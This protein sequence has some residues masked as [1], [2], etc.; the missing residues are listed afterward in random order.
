M[1]SLVVSPCHN[2]FLLCPPRLVS[3]S[4]S[5]TLRE[6]AVFC[7]RSGKWVMKNIYQPHTTNFRQTLLGIVFE[8]RQDESVIY[9]AKTSSLDLPQP[10]DLP[11]NIARVP[12][13][14]MEDLKA[15]AMRRL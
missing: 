3:L 12:M 5:G 9:K 6:K 2:V 8:R 4:N 15:K 1:I 11:R 13:P 14:P 7:K 10:P